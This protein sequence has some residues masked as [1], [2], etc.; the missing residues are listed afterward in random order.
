[1]NSTLG[2]VFNNE[3]HMKVKNSKHDRPMSSTL[4]NMRLAPSM[5]SVDE[6]DGQSQL[7]RYLSGGVTSP[8]PH[9]AQHMTGTVKAKLHV[10][11]R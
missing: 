10:R 9:H 4:N 1:M 11:N 2:M 5:L 8:D 6:D 3:E 7:L